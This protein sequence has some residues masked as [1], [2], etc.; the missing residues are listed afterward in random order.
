MNGDILNLCINI[1]NHALTQNEDFYQ[2]MIKQ[3]Y[4]MHHNF[5]QK[6]T[7]IGQSFQTICF[8]IFNQ[9]IKTMSGKSCI[10]LHFFWE[11]LHELYQ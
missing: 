1:S 8:D 2:G 6:A 11:V 3:S 5:F 9:K 7:I 10:V 4:F